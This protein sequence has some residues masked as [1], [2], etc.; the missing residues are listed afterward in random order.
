MEKNKNVK[1]HRECEGSGKTSRRWCHF[2]KESVE[3]RERSKWVS[4]GRN[5]VGRLKSKGKGLEGREFLYI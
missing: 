4:E 3:V 1:G 5:I 2:G